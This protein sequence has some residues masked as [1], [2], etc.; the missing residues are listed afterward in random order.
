MSD[1][2]ARVM[3]KLDEAAEKLM[4]TNPELTREQAITKVIEADPSWM[5][6]YDRA[7]RGDAKE[8]EATYK[9]QTT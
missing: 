6:D 1:R 7:T 2:R 4:K 5:D 3:T 9:D 8:V